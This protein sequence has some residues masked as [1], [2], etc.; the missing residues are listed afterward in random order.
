MYSGYPWSELRCWKWLGH[1]IMHYMETL[2]PCANE[3][4]Y[5]WCQGCAS[6]DL[7]SACTRDRIGR[8]GSDVL[9][10]C[11]TFDG[12]I[13]CYDL[14]RPT[15]F[16]IQCYGV[17]M[18]Q[19]IETYIHDPLWIHAPWFSLPRCL[20]AHACISPAC[21]CLHPHAIVCGSASTW[22]T[23]LIPEHFRYWPWPTAT[24]AMCS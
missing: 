19:R 21:T 8:K 20:Q 11:P 12:G 10:S 9:T 7:H 18:L 4:A 17:S 14:E 24:S 3:S 6:A 22:H 15:F 13:T 5:T 2:L 1:H 16:P 23:I